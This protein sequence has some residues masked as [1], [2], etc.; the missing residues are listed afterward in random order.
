MYWVSQSLIHTHTL[1][2]EVTFDFRMKSFQS[3]CI[4][5]ISA[6]A[7]FKNIFQK[8]EMIYYLE[9]QG[10]P[11]G[12]GKPARGTHTFCVKY[13]NKHIQTWPK[14]PYWLRFVV[15]SNNWSICYSK[16]YSK[17]VSN[18]LVFIYFH[19]KPYGQFSLNSLNNCVQEQENW[20][21][22]C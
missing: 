5:L 8:S 3:I 6:W 16:T 18:H 11:S 14:Y 9:Q 12:C 13:P 21:Y 19:I 7:L 4:Q 10:T 15:K 22:I 1:L 17:Y 20:I 2:K